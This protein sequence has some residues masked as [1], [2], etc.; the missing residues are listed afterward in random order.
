M[1]LNQNTTA[2]LESALISVV[3][4]IELD[5]DLNIAAHYMQGGLYTYTISGYAESGYA[6]ACGETPRDAL[7]KF[8]CE[9]PTGAALIAQKREE[10]KALLTEAHKLE[11]QTQSQ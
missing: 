6:A 8:R 4:E 9:N 11:T 3:Q 7:E 1:I 2:K 10:A 5:P